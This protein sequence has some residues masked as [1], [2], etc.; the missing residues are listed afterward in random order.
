MPLVRAHL[1][2]KQVRPAH[3]AQLSGYLDLIGLRAQ[4]AYLTCASYVR[5]YIHH[6]PAYRFNS[7][8]SPELGHDLLLHLYHVEQGTVAAPRLLPPS[9]APVSGRRNAA[10]HPSA[11]ARPHDRDDIESEAKL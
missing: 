9:Y 4:R 3:A 11:A 8:V 7:L 1:A 5:E 10:H 6:H 2:A